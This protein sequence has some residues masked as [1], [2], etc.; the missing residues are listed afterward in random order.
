MTAATR[1]LVSDFDGT[2]T[3]H[4]FYKLALDGLLPPDTLDQWAGYRAGEI[5]HFEALRRYFAA[6]RAPEAEV[7]AVVDRM[8]LDP[9]LNAAVA[10]LGAAGWRVVV[11]SAGCDWYIRRLLAAA[12]VEVEVHANPGR[13]EAG[14]LME[15]PV[16]SPYR[17][18]NL[19]V[20][21]A[22]VVRDH[23]AAGRAVAFAGDGFPDAEAARLVPGEQRFARADLA[24]V[25]TREGL[26]FH[27]FDAWSDVA[28]VL[29]RQEG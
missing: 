27:P 19:G 7:L 29:V 23:L 25:L 14:L 2:M 22:R 13:F 26:A 17:C 4:D 21:K 16:G 9:G 6:I 12:G 24:D 10:A 28:R 8:E 18:E 15:K 3:R 20:D 1:V 5:T 11:T